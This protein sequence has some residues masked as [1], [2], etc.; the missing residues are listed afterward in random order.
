MLVCLVCLV[1]EMYLIVSQEPRSLVHFKPER[2]NDGRHLTGTQRF[3]GS[4]RQDSDARRTVRRKPDIT[5]P[6]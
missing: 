5:A 3:P 6:K 1:C 4:R 2:R